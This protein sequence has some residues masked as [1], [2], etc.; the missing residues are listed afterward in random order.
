MLAPLK[1]WQ[2]L[3]SSLCQA[4]ADLTRAV[5]Y[6]LARHLRHE[7]TSNTKSGQGACMGRVSDTSGRHPRS[8][9]S[10]LGHFTAHT[11]IPLCKYGIVHIRYQKHMQIK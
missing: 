8:F 1:N 11:D 9:V 4:L 7:A 3:L 2:L 10:S 5:S 6:L